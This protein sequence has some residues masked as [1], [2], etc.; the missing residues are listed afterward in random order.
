MA[1]RE[2]GKIIAT[3]KNDEKAK[4]SV[5]GLNTATVAIADPAGFRI[6][7]ISFLA[8]LTGLLAGIVAFGLY[9]LI[10]LLTNLIFYG[11]ASGAF[12]SAKDNHLGLW[13]IPIPV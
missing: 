7:L 6:V 11:H 10:G 1:E 13:V 9:K 12:V 5:T 4:L 3:T 2:S 8:A